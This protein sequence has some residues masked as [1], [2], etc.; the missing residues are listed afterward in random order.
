MILH[1]RSK[2]PVPARNLDAQ[3]FLNGQVSLDVGSQIIRLPNFVF[4]NLISSKTVL[5]GTVFVAL[6]ALTSFKIDI[7]M[8][9]SKIVTL[10]ARSHNADPAA[11]GNGSTVSN[12][13]ITATGLD[14]DLKTIKGSVT[15]SNLAKN[16]R[17]W[18]RVKP[19]SGLKGSINY[20]SISATMYISVAQSGS[21]SKGT[22]LHLGG[23]TT[24]I[25][26]IVT[27][28]GTDTNTKKLQ[29]KYGAAAADVID[30]KDNI[31]NADATRQ[32][33]VA[34]DIFIQNVNS[35]KGSVITNLNEVVDR[36]GSA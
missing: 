29:F 23:N 6:S 13:E 26:F 17:F 36:I 22:V 21:Y 28:V 7:F 16:R 30:L 24:P 35:P 32:S 19:T 18:F 27:A 15:I 33:I 8:K 10:Q 1:T 4:T 20:S 14:P 25:S 9:A 34:Q 31:P 12:G 3:S 5:D 2:R 11:P